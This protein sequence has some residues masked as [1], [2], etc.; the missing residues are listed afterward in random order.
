MLS[1]TE[2]RSKSLPAD[3]QHKPFGDYSFSSGLNGAKSKEKGADHKKIDANCPKKEPKS[4]DPCPDEINKNSN[5]TCPFKTLIYSCYNKQWVYSSSPPAP[6]SGAGKIK[7]A[8]SNKNSTDGEPENDKNC[9]SKEPEVGGPC[10][11]KSLEC[12]FKIKEG[13]KTF[14]CPDKKWEFI[15]VGVPLAWD[16]KGNPIGDKNKENGTDWH[17]TITWDGVSCPS[18][19]PKVGDACKHK[20]LKCPFKTKEGNKT[21]TCPSTSL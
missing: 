11:D 21:F 14:T 1:V 7:E 2:S 13:T 20:G 18:K 12:L 4:G 15:A 6:S 9:P 19:E 3:K 5:V 8:K 10:K 17:N 16:A